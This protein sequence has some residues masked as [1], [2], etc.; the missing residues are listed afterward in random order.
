MIKECKC[1]NKE[2]K[3]PCPVND[4]KWKI[5]GAYFCSYSCYS[6][7]FDKLYKAFN[8]SKVSVGNTRGRVVDKGYERFG[9]R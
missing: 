9:S 6:K 7:T 1:C 3:V 4:F 8:N 2:F 5:K